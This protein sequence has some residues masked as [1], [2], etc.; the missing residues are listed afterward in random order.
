MNTI[1]RTPEFDAWLKSL[2]DGVGRAAIASRIKRAQGGNFGDAAPVGDGVFEM[3]IHFGPGYRVY[4]FQHGSTVYVLT[5]GGDKG[6]QQ[7]DIARAK[8]LAKHYGE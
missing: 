8:E 3:R 1:R 5:N 6:S 2:K 4:Y 7:R